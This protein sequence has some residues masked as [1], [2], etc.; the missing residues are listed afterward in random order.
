MKKYGKCAKQYLQKTILWIWL[1]T[2]FVPMR[3]ITLMMYISG[4]SK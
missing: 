3:I 2:L 1:A 4:T